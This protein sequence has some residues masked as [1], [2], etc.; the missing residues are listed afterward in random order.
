MLDSG[1]NINKVAVSLD[2]STAYIY[3]RI[4]LLTLCRGCQELF[5]SGRITVGQAIEISAL[6]DERMQMKAAEIATSKAMSLGTF[7][8]RIAGMK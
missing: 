3:K 5:R 7:R 4:R 2:V 1:E 8:L 6:A